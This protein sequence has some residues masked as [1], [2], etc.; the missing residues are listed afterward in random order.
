MADRMTAVVT[1]GVGGPEMLDV[2]RVPVPNPGP[3]E[4]RLRVLAA[5]INNTDINT[6]TGWYAAE[7]AG[8]TGEGPTHEGGGWSGATPFPMIQGT[9]CCGRVDAVGP[10]GDAARIGDRVIV[11]SCLRPGGDDDPSSRWLGV[12]FDGAFAE[13]VVVPEDAAFAVRCDWSD[14]ELA[15]VPCASGTAENLLHRAGVGPGDL[16]LVTGASG[17]VGSAAVQL[18]RRRGAEVIGMAGRAK[19]DA[20]RALGAARTIDRGDDPA[21]VLGED[22]VDV[23]IDLVGGTG[24]GSLVR[25]L[26][27]RGR[28]A[29]SGAIAGASVTL[30]LRQLYLKDLTMVG[31]TA[32]DGAVFPSVV[33]AVEA[34]EIRP[35]L[36]ATWPLDRIAE[37]QEAFARKD[38]V[39][40]IVLIPPGAD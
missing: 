13:Y 7:A 21:E 11:Q 38:F 12:D 23:V 40:K 14:A 2:T 34:G 22:S 29:T 15:T 27:R 10:G 30:D 39:G 35:M 3:G 19:H 31:G 33:A 28:Y 17:G 16:V 24:F 5:A 32:W 25:A 20:V 6:R 37:A 18:A 36:A 26:R 1:R 8:G 4:V 9:D